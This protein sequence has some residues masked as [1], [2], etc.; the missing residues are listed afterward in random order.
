MLM[1]FNVILEALESK[2]NLLDSLN[3]KVRNKLGADGINDEIT[4]T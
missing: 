4:M 2:L 1:H 3:E